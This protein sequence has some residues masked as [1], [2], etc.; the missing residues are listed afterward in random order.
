[1]TTR[2]DELL[3]VLAVSLGPAPDVEPTGAEISQLHRVIDSGWS[4]QRRA[5][6][7]IWR[8][9]RPLTAAVAG[10]F[11][12]GGASAAAAVSGA[13]M[14]QP[15]RVA[16]R[17]VGFPVDSP[18]LAG[19]RGALGRL[20]AALG[21]Q[22]RDLAAI[23]ATAQEVR[24]RLGRLS[25]DD[26]VHVED[27]A[28]FLL[29]DADAA[30]APPSTPLGPPQPQ[31]PPAVPT[32]AAPVAPSRP[33]NTVPTADDHGDRV[34]EP[35]HSGTGGDDHHSSDDGSHASSVQPGGSSSSGPGP[36]G[37]SGG[38]DQTA[39]TQGV[40]NSGHGSSD[41]GG[42]SDGGSSHDGGGSSGSDGGGHSGPG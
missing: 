26:R 21:D 1:V 37:S 22:P 35:E 6:T 20:R 36:S 4:N 41:G 17:A 2:D 15:M 42:G 12:L 34:A 10:L 33:S 9:R 19:A 29:A 16:A 31:N 39:T 18:E 5:R 30:L 25:A 7:P 13:V 23:R 3:D 11:V 14:P 28:H 32:D 8:I 38:G 24:D 40:D 27:E